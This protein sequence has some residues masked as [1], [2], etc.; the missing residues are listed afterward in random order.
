MFYIQGRAGRVAAVHLQR[1]APGTAQ[2][3]SR[4]AVRPERHRPQQP[5]VSA[6]RRSRRLLLGAQRLHGLRD[7]ARLAKLRR[8]RPGPIRAGRKLQRGLELQVAR[9]LH[10][11]T[12]RRVVHDAGRRA[13]QPGRELDRTSTDFDARQP[14]HDERQLRHEHRR[15]SD[16]T[17]S[18]RT[19]R[20]RRSRRRSTTRTRSAR[21]RSM[22]ARR[23]SNTRDASRSIRRFPTPHASRRRRSASATVLQLDA[24]LQ[25]QPQRR[26]EAST[27]RALVPRYYLHESDHRAAGTARTPRTRA[28][29]RRSS[30]SFDTPITIFGWDLKNSFRLN[31][32]RNDFPQQFTIYDVNT[33]ASIDQRVFA[34]TY[35]TATRLDA[36]RSRCR[37]FARQ[38]VQ[39]HA[40]LQPEQRR[41]GAV[42]GRVG[43]DERRVRSPG[44]AHHRCGVSRVADDLRTFPGLRPVHAHS[45]HDQRRR[46]ATLGAGERQ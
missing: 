26:V 4:A 1:R 36:G 37:P 21:R 40:E 39:P 5:D 28:I 19:R 33:G 7:V 14:H 20:S 24:E 12:H 6:P 42:L 43:T 23:A 9:P 10:R 34:A 18:T 32:A 3:H 11:R 35:N 41:P 29:R 17:R 38:P 13:A 2:R 44:E 8:R 31:Q 27:S 45:A 22:S 25:L 16:R 46:S 30:M 15:C